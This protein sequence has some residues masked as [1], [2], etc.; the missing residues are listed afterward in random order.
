MENSYAE[1]LTPI[2]TVLR[3]GA[4]KEVITTDEVI[5]VGPGPA[6]LVSLQEK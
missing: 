5:R 6:G 3:D 1:A 2:V 4:F